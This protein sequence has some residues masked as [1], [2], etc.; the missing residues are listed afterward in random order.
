MRRSKQALFYGIMVVMTLAVIEGMAQAAY[1]IAYGEFNGGG[2]AAPAAT[3]AADA[4][5]N[6]RLPWRPWIQ[7]PYYG[8]TRKEAHHP[9]NQVPPPRRQDGVVLVALLGGSVGLE[10]TYAFRKALEAWFRD[11]GIPLQPVVLELASHALKQPQQVMQISNTLFLGGEYDIIVNLDGYNELIIPYDNHFWYGVSPFYP[12][13]WQ[14]DQRY[15]LTNT[16][17]LV[18]SRIYALRQRAERLDAA[19][20]ARPWRWSALYGIANR[21]LRENTAAQILD[22]NRELS[23]TRTG[24]YSLQRYGPALTF[25]PDEY[26]LSQMALRGWYRG[27]VLLDELSRVAGAEYY[28]F[29]QPNQYVPDSKP[30]SD[31]ERAVAYDPEHRAISI[32]RDSYPL[33]RRLG[34]ELRQQGINYYDLTQLFADNRET[35]YKDDCC[36]LN[37]R[38]NEL[39][40]ASMVRHLE[41]A[42]RQRAALSAAKLGGGDIIVVDMALDA[43]TQ[44]ISPI[45]AI[46]KLYFDVRYTAA[47]NLRYSRDACRP[48]DTTAPFFVRIAPM[49]AD[50]LLPGGDA[51][52]YNSDDFAFDRNGGS[53]D[54]AGRCVL[55]YRLPDYEIAYILTGQYIPGTEQMLWRARITLDTGFEVERTG[56]GALRY[57][58]DDCWPV[59]IGTGFFLHITPVD[60]A[61]LQPVTAEHGFNNYDF[62]GFTKNDGIIDAAGRCVIERELPDY[63]IA[64]I[65]TGQY[66][67]DG[68]RRLWETHID[69]E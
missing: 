51:S 42:L 26:D 30:L 39:L 21:Y 15:S 33:L 47:G 37:A 67:P 69:F 17:N 49:A 55:E 52:G 68:K 46:N 8:H 25:D 2:P 35:L 10:V 45:H 23:D 22:L 27:S 48:A 31:E 57:S 58:R 59:H 61:D 66:T 16:Q 32:Y 53:I 40:A 65:L 6:E 3:A 64:S 56:T 13:N 62:S 54:A 19:A 44:E 60:A 4:A 29:L 14:Q 9:L 7:H 43:A 18:V 50:D 5:G 20:G 24:D 63:D 1:Y 12:W 34:E 36:H 28:H 38:G 41:P 11:N